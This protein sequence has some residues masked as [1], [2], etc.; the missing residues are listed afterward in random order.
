MKQIETMPLARAQPKHTGKVYSVEHVSKSRPTAEGPRK[1]RNGQRFF[2]AMGGRRDDL[3]LGRACVIGAASSFTNKLTLDG[4]WE[5]YLHMTERE[6]LRAIQADL[7]SVKADVASIR[8]AVS[9]LNRQIVWLARSGEIGV[10]HHD[11]NLLQ[12]GF[13]DLEARVEVIEQAQR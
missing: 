6:T 5:G 4:R 13:A 3:T 2:I 1:V 9:A 8:E 12:Q 11:I 10:L 7:A